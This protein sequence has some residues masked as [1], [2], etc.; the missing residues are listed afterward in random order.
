MATAALRVSGQSS[1]YLVRPL[2]VVRSNDEIGSEFAQHAVEFCELAFD[3]SQVG[4]QLGNLL[5]ARLARA[6]VWPPPRPSH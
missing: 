5:R 4:L 2:H 6:T 3:P 1:Q